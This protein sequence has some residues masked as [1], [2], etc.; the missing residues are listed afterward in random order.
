MVGKTDKLSR[1]VPRQVA[2]V[3]PERAEWNR[4]MPLPH[5]G[6]EMGKCRFPAGDAAHLPPGEEARVWGGP[7]SCGQTEVLHQHAP[8]ALDFTHQRDRNKELSADGTGTGQRTAPSPARAPK[9]EPVFSRPEAEVR[10][11]HGL[12]S[13]D[14][15]TPT[16]C[17]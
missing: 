5:R 10:V 17:L 3:F 15:A 8:C 2:F 16:V 1:E 11:G 7:A 13:Q 12:R 6:H 4:H 14:W 9:V